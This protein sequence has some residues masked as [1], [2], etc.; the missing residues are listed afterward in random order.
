M[1][2]IA[3][4]I[5]EWTAETF[6]F[7]LEKLMRKPI[8][9]EEQIVI[10]LRYFATGESFTNLMF[11]FRVSDETTRRLIPRVSWGIVCTLEKLMPFPRISE[12]WETIYLILP[13]IS[14]L[15]LVYETQPITYN[16][17]ID[18]N[19]LSTS[20]VWDSA[21]FSINTLILFVS[22]AFNW[23][24]SIPVKKVSETIN[25]PCAV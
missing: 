14:S 13:V 1:R 24:S 21:E 16:K 17:I 22:Y 12:D 11:Q 6:E 10:T 9:P 2:R 19:N 20:L 25:R 8:F 5:C 4:N 23:L 3:E 18:T 15:I 7:L